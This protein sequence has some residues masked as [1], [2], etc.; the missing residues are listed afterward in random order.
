MQWLKKFIMQ[1]DSYMNP[2]HTFESILSQ[3]SLLLKL[4]NKR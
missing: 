3:Q 2:I 1:S 4:V